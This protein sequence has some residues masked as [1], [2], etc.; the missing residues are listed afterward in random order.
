MPEKDLAAEP[1]I[2]REDDSSR[3][4]SEE[5]LE[6]LIRQ[7]RWLKTFLIIAYL[8]AIVLLVLSSFR[9]LGYWPLESGEHSTRPDLIPC[10]KPQIFAHP[11]CKTISGSLL[12]KLPSNP[13]R[14]SGKHESSRRIITEAP[15]LAILVPSLIWPGIGCLKVSS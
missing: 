14:S 11:I 5:L 6:K 2:D 4:N 15:T 8:P 9:W 10:K 13:M 3:R 1:L 12:S 7:Y